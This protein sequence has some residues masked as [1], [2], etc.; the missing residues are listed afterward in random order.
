MGEEPKQPK[1]RLDP[2]EFLLGIVCAVPTVY[3]AAT[4][5]GPYRWI[6]EMQLRWMGM[7][8]GGITFV[9]ALFLVLVPLLGVRFLVKKLAFS[10]QREEGAD[11]GWW[12][13]V[14]KYFADLML[15]LIGVIF[16]G[17]GAFLYFR[18][19]GEA[20]A[21]AVDVADL[22]GGKRAGKLWLEVSGR[23]LFDDAGA[24]E[25]NHVTTYYAPVV[26]ESWS[27]GNPVAVYLEVHERDLGQELKN[28]AVGKYK[29]MVTVGGLP[30]MARE[31]LKKRGFGPAEGYVMLDYKN[32]PA[33]VQKGARHLMIAGA[34]VG[35]VGLVIAGYQ[36]WKM[37][38]MAPGEPVPVVAKLQIKSIVQ[39]DD[40][41]SRQ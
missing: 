21:T 29:G 11:P 28:K 25:K 17:V 38:R 31:D 30:G 23:L 14:S 41:A 35:A 24:V 40:R 13:Q 26:S 3:W 7:Y 32:G 22:E 20:Q 8:E 37:G 15:V 39:L 10:K 27:S 9:L 16:V 4:Y 12:Q 33:D 1:E 6:A 36:R 34:V 19:M 18:V 5:S 2:R